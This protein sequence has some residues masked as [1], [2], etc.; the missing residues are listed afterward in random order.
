MAASEAGN[1]SSQQ[2]FMWQV[3]LWHW[4]T[5]KVDYERQEK[6]LTFPC[7][8]FRSDASAKSYKVR[9]FWGVGEKLRLSM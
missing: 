2:I 7:E 6:D 5:T 8:R 3:S 1:E 4:R 9:N